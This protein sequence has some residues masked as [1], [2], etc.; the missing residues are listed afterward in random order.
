MRE[1]DVEAGLR[2]VFGDSMNVSTS[3]ES[4]EDD[5]DQAGEPKPFFDEVAFEEVGGIGMLLSCQHAGHRSWGH[6]RMMYVSVG[7]AH[8]HRHH[9]AARGAAAIR[10]DGE[11]ADRDAET[12]AHRLAAAA[13][14]LLGYHHPRAARTGPGTRTAIA[15]TLS[16]WRLHFL[17]ADESG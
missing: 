4:D 16:V 11:P 3:T 13:G 10:Q 5:Y 7:D 15:V 2:A 12:S 17:S 8:R 9:V 1:A 6:A 14:P